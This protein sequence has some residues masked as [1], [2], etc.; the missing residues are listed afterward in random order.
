M[1]KLLLTVAIAAAISGCDNQARVASSNLSK[2]ADNFEVVRRVVFYNTWMD[3]YLLTIEGLCSMGYDNSK[4]AVTCKVG[5]NE[6]KKHYVTLSGHMTVVTEQL[7]PAKVNTYHYRVIFR[8]ATLV[9]AIE[10][11]L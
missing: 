11:D 9:P 10:M 8:P 1:K 4:V 5:A 2:A 6:Y 3:K 7:E